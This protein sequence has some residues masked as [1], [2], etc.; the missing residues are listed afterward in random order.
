MKF[1]ILQNFLLYINRV[2]F[3]KMYTIKLMNKSYNKR[4]INIYDG[5]KL[6]VSLIPWHGWYAISVAEPELRGY[7]RSVAMA[8][9]YWLLG[10]DCD[11][12]A[13]NNLVNAWDVGKHVFG[14]PVDQLTSMFFDEKEKT[15]AINSF[16]NI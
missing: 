15:I 10:K 14:V 6:I 2:R 16:Y 5:K 11:F 8:N 4:K 12:E 3:Y 1:C 13:W 9:L 7:A